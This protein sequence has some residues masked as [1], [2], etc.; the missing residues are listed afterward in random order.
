MGLPGIKNMQEILR[1]NIEYLARY[2]VFFFSTAKQYYCNFR[3][4]Q[5]FVYDN[6]FLVHNSFLIDY[7]NLFRGKISRGI[8]V[9]TLFTFEYSTLC[10]LFLKPTLLEGLRTFTYVFKR[11]KFFSFSQIHARAGGRRQG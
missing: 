7:E 10:T 4:N 6:Y 1:S 5:M 2:N 11:E 8:L 9:M 3:Y